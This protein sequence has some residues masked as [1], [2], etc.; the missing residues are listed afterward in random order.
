M[1]LELYQRREDLDRRKTKTIEQGFAGTR[2]NGTRDVF[3]K[4]GCQN[5]TGTLWNRIKGGCVQCNRMN[6]KLLIPP[7][8]SVKI[9]LD[10]SSASM[11]PVGR[12]GLGVSHYLLAF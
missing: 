5:F 11:E 8:R 6:V 2:I 9:V 7:L 10:E 12:K 1:N 4:N 3:Y